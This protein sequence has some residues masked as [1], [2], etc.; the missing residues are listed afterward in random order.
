MVLKTAL[1]YLCACLALMLFSAP[2]LAE[3]Y[4][5]EI[6]DKAL[7][8]SGQ[9]MSPFCPGRMLRDCPSSGASELKATIRS[10]LSE[11]KNTEEVISELFELYGDD[12]KA[13]PDDSLIGR[14]AWLAPFFFILFGFVVAGLWLRANFKATPKTEP[15]L[16]KA[17]DKMNP[18]LMKRIESELDD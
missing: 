8:I 13:L 15:P 3:R 4:S 17:A 10:L 5:H 18:E 1:I 9:V 2:L 6:E 14:S 11:G 12:I 7:H 16:K